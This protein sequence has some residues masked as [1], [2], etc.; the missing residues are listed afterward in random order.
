MIV[1]Q[2]WAEA[3]AQ[4]RDRK[5]QITVRRF[6]WSD[7]S[8]EDAQ[9]NADVRVQDALQR[10]VAGEKLLRREP[11]VS[12]NGAAGVPIREEI[13]ERHG[14]GIVTRNLYGARCLNTPDVLFADVDYP[15]KSS[16]RLMFVG[17]LFAVG[18]GVISGFFSYPI[19]VFVG[20]MIVVA[21]ILR[22]LSE[23]VSYRKND[24]EI[25][26]LKLKNFIMTHPAWRLRLYRTPAGLRLLAMHRKFDPT[27]PEVDAF[28]RAIGADPIYVQMCKNQRCFRARVSPKPWRIGIEKHLRPR[29]GVWPVKPEHEPRRQAWIAEYEAKSLAFASCR[30][31][32]DLGD[33]LPD[34]TVQA[35]CTCTMK[36]AGRTRRC[37]LRDENLKINSSLRSEQRSFCDYSIEIAQF[38]HSRLG[39]RIGNSFHTNC[40]FRDS[41]Q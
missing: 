6:G 41:Y 34:F 4:Y 39:L 12:Y 30:Y 35:V 29:P 33:G 9:R 14:N 11:R 8:Q 22:F 19:L 13:L 37:R 16:H 27:E 26:L 20:L 28:F 5:K 7:E 10:L 17:I 31:L 25:A 40:D 24:E 36:C 21:G 2:F 18:V 23:K 15:D 38:Q 3:R 1:P 32:C